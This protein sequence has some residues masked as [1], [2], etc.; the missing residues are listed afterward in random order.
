MK[1]KVFKWKNNS[2][3]KAINGLD[4]KT[5]FSSEYTAMRLILC[6]GDQLSNKRRRAYIKH[7]IIFVF[8]WGKR[9]TLYTEHS[10]RGNFPKRN[11]SFEIVVGIVWFSTELKCL[12]CFVWLQVLWNFSSKTTRRGWADCKIKWILNFSGDHLLPSSLNIL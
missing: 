9:V 8:F 3:L 12:K 1:I 2:I 4:N 11:D 5:V 7:Q 10:F 6:I